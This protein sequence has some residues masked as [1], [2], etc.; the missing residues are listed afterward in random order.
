MSSK[1]NVFCGDQ[2]PVGQSKKPAAL[3]S[4]VPGQVGE[5]LVNDVV[6][7]EFF[8]I[9]VNVF[10]VSGHSDSFGYIK[11]EAVDQ[12]VSCL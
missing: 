9:S 6:V 2:R 11:N 3:Q 12:A 8:L 10:D 7:S 4:K 5:L 1:I